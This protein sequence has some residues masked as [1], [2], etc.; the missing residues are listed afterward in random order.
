MPADER[1]EPEH[2]LAEAR[3]QQNEGLGKLLDCYRNYL[4]LVA[5]TQIDLHLQGRLDASD[6]VQETYLDA[7]RDFGHFRGS[8]EREL[9]A[10]L[11][12][13]LV[14]NIARAVR[15]QVGTQKRD[16]R[17]DISLERQMAAL[18][19][20]SARLEAALASPHSSPSM[21]AQKRERANL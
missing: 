1:P 9:L 14:C 17:R 7:C 10:W 19:E 21:Q 15:T 8:S 2:L 11:R 5:R 16:A 4:H 18:E 20:S 3:A 12:Q 6:L 13:I